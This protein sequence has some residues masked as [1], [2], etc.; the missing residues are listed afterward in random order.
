MKGSVRMFLGAVCL[1]LAGPRS[2]LAQVEVAPCFTMTFEWRTASTEIDNWEE[3]K[4][5]ARYRT[6]RMGD[7]HGFVVAGR[8]DDCNIAGMRAGQ[9]RRFPL[10]WLS[11]SAV[12]VL[13]SDRRSANVDGP[14]RAGDASYVEAE[15]KEQGAVLRFGIEIVPTDEEAFGLCGAQTWYPSP[16]VFQVTEQELSDFGSIHKVLLL[17]MP[18]GE[19]NC[20]GKGVATLTAV[21]P[22]SR[23]SLDGCSELAVG[24]QSTVTARGQ[25]AGGSYRFQVDPVS[26][27]NVTAQEGSATISGTAP[28]QATLRV[29]YTAPGG[30]SGRASQP[31]TILRV[32]SINGGEPVP[33][34]AFFDL[35]G[36][37]TPPTRS[38]PVSVQPPAA[39]ELL[40]YRPA[41]PGMLS[42][43][44]RGQS[45]LLQGIRVGK[46]TFQA[47]TSCGGATGPIVDVEVAYCDDDV[48][49]RL[50]LLESNYQNALRETLREDERVRSSDEFRQADRIA[51]STADLRDKTGALLIGTLATGAGKATQTGAHLLLHGMNLRDGLHGKA[52]TAALQSALLAA[53]QAVAGA[54]I[55][56]QEAADAAARFGND[57][58]AVMYTTHRLAQLRREYARYQALLMD[59]LRR[60]RICRTGSEEPPERTDPPAREDD[61]TEPSVEEDPTEPLALQPAQPEPSGQAG[62]PYGGQDCG[63]EA[64]S[65]ALAGRADGAGLEQ[66]GRALGTTQACVEQFSGGPLTRYQ[67]TLGEWDVVLRELESA[68]AP[69]Q[70]PASGELISRLDDLLARTVDFSEEGSLFH[71]R[72]ESC[73]ATVDAAVTAINVS[74]RPE[75]R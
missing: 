6:M 8:E 39:G 33:T 65:Q 47:V 62:L 16:P 60:Q 63:C 2:A 49:R 66:I 15:R 25:P 44:G 29:D 20:E 43:V 58:G 17:T 23:V 5:E 72:F 68:H 36:K 59:V 21:A 13:G 22:T 11:G 52:E 41:D 73:P 51:E 30:S 1:A 61:P 3:Q 24:Q 28:G 34:I 64:S 7:P 14:P 32:E 12:A 37:R 74:P 56:A 75:L 18:L 26:G 70:S 48:H 9:V 31:V 53:R 40:V 42:T 55:S 38:V 4:V 27:L 57:L 35:E 69:G 19:N 46:T 54:V 10:A 50:G 71:A 45:I 67:A